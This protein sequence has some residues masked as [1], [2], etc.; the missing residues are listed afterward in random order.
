MLGEH[1]FNIKNPF[2]Y[3]QFPHST[4]DLI[5]SLCNRETFIKCE[6]NPPT[7]TS[8]LQIVINNV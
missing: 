5:L 7:Q 2:I 6:E 8:F 3:Q 1:V 4:L